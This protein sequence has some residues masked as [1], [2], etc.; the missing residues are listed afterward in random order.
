MNSFI[1][2]LLTLAALV[3]GG[4]VGL[5]FGLLQTQARLQNKKLSEDGKL[6]SNWKILPGSFGR[7]A[8]LL[9]VLALI[10]LGVPMLFK[11]NIQWI[12][13]LG[14]LLGYGWTFV[15]QLKQRAMYRN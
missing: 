13:S 14:I 2:T 7:I 6:K 3:T 12:V 11:G 1:E 9:I 8:L 10:Q 5:L 15:R 4:I